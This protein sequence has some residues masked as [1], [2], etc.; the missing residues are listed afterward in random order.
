[1]ASDTMVT[2][3]TML[4]QRRRVQRLLTL[5]PLSET[6]ERDMLYG[7]MQALSWALKDDA[8]APVHLSNPSL[9]RG[10]DHA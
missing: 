6:R 10:P 8:A 5:L 2:R 9:L 4:T 3:S 7:A 1:M